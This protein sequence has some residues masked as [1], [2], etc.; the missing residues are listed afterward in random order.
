MKFFVFWGT[1]NKFNV[2]RKLFPVFLCSAKKKNSV[3]SFEEDFFFVQSV[4]HIDCH[5]VSCTCSLMIY[6]LVSVFTDTSVTLNVLKEI[7]ILLNF[8][9]LLLTKFYIAESRIWY[10]FIIYAVNKKKKKLR[11]NI[12]YYF[13]NFIVLDLNYTIL[14]FDGS[15]NIF[16]MKEEIHPFNL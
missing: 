11:K 13:N 3:C 15:H 9:L 12:F 8:N 1:A 2:F 5:W 10:D 14:G 4:P 7:Y 6:T 16:L